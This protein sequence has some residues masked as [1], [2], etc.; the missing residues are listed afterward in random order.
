M[1]DLLERLF[2]LPDWMGP[3]QLVSFSVACGAIAPL[4]SRDE[5]PTR[6]RRVASAVAL[7]AM[8]ATII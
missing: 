6:Y 7:V 4:M 8:V 3:A 1:G 2:S 5:C